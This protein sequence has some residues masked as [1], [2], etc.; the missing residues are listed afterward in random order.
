MAMYIDKQGQL[1]QR[2][3]TERVGKLAGAMGV[4]VGMGLRS[5]V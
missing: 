5:W 2:G 1:L 4:V 3:R